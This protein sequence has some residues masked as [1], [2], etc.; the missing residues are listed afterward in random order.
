MNGCGPVVNSDTE[1]L[2]RDNLDIDYTLYKSELII[3]PLTGLNTP[4]VGL[5][6][7]F[8]DF[9][10]LNGK[11]IKGI[12]FLSSGSLSQI[13]YG[14]ATYTAVSSTNLRQ[15]SISIFDATKNAYS[16]EL[17]PLVSLISPS[18]VASGQ[19]MK[20]PFYDLE[21]DANLRKSFIQ[22]NRITGLSSSNALAINFYYQD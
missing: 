18:E 21:I 7:Y 22:F 14:G 13:N 11:K 20:Y 10:N 3:I 19:V 15:L 4:K 1:N 12:T 17:L 9:G 8:A 2:L 16:I 6:V 5:R